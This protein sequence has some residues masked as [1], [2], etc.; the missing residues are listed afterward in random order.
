[1]TEYR[2][3]TTLA[4]QTLEDIAIQEYGAVEGIE[5]LVRDNRNTLAEG[6]DTR[7]PTGTLLRIRVGESANAK[8]LD[9]VQRKN[10]KPATGEPEEPPLVGPD[11]ND[12]H[13][14]DHSI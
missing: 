14:Y 11:H 6:F 5:W 7:M 3:I 12:D 13:N 1:M 10:I 2:D 4:R 8:I 9:E